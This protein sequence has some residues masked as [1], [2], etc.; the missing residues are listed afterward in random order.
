MTDKPQA[1]PDAIDIVMIGRVVWLHKVLIGLTCI[2]CGLVAAV[3]ALTA[4]KIYRADVIVTE[5]H[6]RGLGAGSSLVDRLGGIASLAGVNLNADSGGQEAQAVLDSRRLVE[7]FIKRNNLLPEL[8]RNSSEPASLWLTVKRFKTGVL[9]I[10]KDI[11]K[12]ITTVSI[13]WTDPV[14]AAR[15]ANGF[16][17]LAND[18]IRARALEDA[19]RNIDYLNAVEL[20]RVMFN[21]IENETKNLMLARGRVE[22]AFEVVDPAVPPEVRARPQRVLMVSVG[23]VVGLFIGITIAFVLER[24]GRNVRSSS[25]E[26]RKRRDQVPIL[27]ARG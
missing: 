19:K 24:L 2:A 14:T 8:S 13:E 6:D 7:E 3:F 9:T 25:V 10:N 17:A 21:I 16:V 12:G 22:Y 1:N 27:D 18:L 11:R 15:W 23:L 26:Q 4:T 5:V 20:R